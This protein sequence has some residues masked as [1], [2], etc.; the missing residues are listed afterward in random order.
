MADPFLTLATA[1]S[2]VDVLVRACKGTITI[3]GNWKDAPAAIQSLRSHLQGIQSLLEH[4]R[5][6][7]AEYESSELVT[8]YH[9]F[10]PEFV[11]RELLATQSDLDALQ[12]LLPSSVAKKTSQTIKW[13]TR[14]K[15]L[16]DAVHRL[17]SRKTGLINGFESVEQ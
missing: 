2:F 5:L 13:V 11:K 1:L 10:F 17:E 9:L 3:I 6:V 16:S 15:K 4:L 8:Q 7:A 14:E 12:Q